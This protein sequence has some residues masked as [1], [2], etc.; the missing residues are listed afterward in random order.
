MAE[1]KDLIICIPTYKRKWPA[2]LSF[3][4]YTD[5][6]QFTLCVRKEDYEEGYYDE[7]QFDMPNLGFMLLENVHCIGETREQILQTSIK[8][9]Y[10]YC[11][12]M[13]DTQY[14]LHDTSNRITTFKTILQNCLDRFETDIF[15]DRAFAFNFG[16]KA[17]SND[18]KRQKTYFISQLCQTYIINLAL[19]QKY[20]LHFKRMD[21]VGVED[22]VFYIEAVNKGLVALS[23]TRFIR[24][25][26]MPSVKK[27]GGCH[28]GNEK[29]KERDVQN[30]RF[31]TMVKYLSTI[32]YDTNL[33]KFMQS[34]LH[35]GTSYYKFN[36][37]YAKQK[38]FAERPIFRD[39]KFN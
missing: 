21:L 24:I 33:L 4:R 8:L 32:E 5:D 20:D 3:I 38:L 30:E 28:Y 6:I 10:K 29:R 13:D 18:V 27:T 12:M 35:P 34:V 17:M 22:L 36:T 15:R 23:D 16:R 19:V 31:A 25:G 9:G 26:Q 2:I 7:P 11:M 1:I 39:I 14:G 37:R